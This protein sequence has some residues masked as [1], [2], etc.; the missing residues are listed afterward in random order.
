MRQGTQRFSYGLAQLY[1]DQ[2]PEIAAEAI[3]PLLAWLAPD[4]G[5][6]V[7][8]FELREPLPGGERVF[9]L[10][11]SWELESLVRRDERLGEDLRRSWQARALAGRDR[12][13][14]GAL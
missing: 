11:L 2:D 4:A 5:A 12:S 3:A 9:E 10:E 6:G 7:Q 14:E 1:D 8:R 13:S